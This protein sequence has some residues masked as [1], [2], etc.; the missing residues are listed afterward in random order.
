MG[1]TTVFTVH[2]NFVQVAALRFGDINGAHAMVVGADP[3][4]RVVQKLL[5]QIAAKECGLVRGG[6]MVPD[7]VTDLTRSLDVLMAARI[8]EQGRGEKHGLLAAESGETRRHM[9]EGVLAKPVPRV[10]KQDVVAT[11]V[12][13]SFIHCVENSVVGFRRIDCDVFRVFPA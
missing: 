12:S 9:F 11:G 10:E 13:Q 1:I 2:H 5:M 7:I 4:P 8:F 3:V 6:C